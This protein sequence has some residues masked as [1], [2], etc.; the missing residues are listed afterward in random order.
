MRVEYAGQPR[1]DGNP[2]GGLTL[3]SLG[4]GTQ[5]DHVM[6]SNAGDGCFGF[7]GGAV[8]ADHLIALNGNGDLFDGGNGY[9]GKLQFL[10]GRQFPTTWQPDSHGI[11]VEG[12]PSRQNAPATS[13]Q[14]SNFTLC[15]GGSI[16]PNSS[17]DGAVLRHSS[18]QV[19]LMNGI[20]TGFAGAG[21]FVQTDQSSR[22]SLSFMQL[23]SNTSGPLAKVDLNNPSL[24]GEDQT[25]FAEQPGNST[26]KPDGFC[27]CW[28]NPPVPVAESVEQGTRPTGFSD[29]SADE[30]GAFKDLSAASNWMRGA[31]VDWTSQ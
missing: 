5:L 9:S 28:A 2:A 12:T 18:S 19:S 29:D 31:W 14:I 8:N 24:F 23:F 6:V 20:V 27:D 17:R 3:A 13:E 21:L 10:F 7:F 1:V 26:K 30:I 11:A 4:S 25:W 15:G 22:A 16:D